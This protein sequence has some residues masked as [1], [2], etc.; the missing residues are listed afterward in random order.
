MRD[1][2]RRGPAPPARRQSLS[3]AAVRGDGRPTR[4]T[5]WLAV[6]RNG[7]GQLAPWHGHGPAAGAR[8]GAARAAP[9]CRPGRPEWHR[10]PASRRCHPGSGPGDP[11]VSASDSGSA[12]AA[13]AGR[14]W[15]QSLARPV[16]VTGPAGAAAAEPESLALTGGQCVSV[17]A[18]GPGKFRD[19]D[20]GPGKFNRD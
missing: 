9:A 15:A 1:G 18:S 3:H 13:P 16:A 20:S 4:T 2:P 11:P 10:G 14:H 12:P 7:P 17:H 19:S 5:A 6:T 8:R